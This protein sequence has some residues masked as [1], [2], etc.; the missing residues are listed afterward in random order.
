M[1]IAEKTTMQTMAHIE[2][3]DNSL[4]IFNDAIYIYIGDALH[5][6]YLF[7]GDLNALVSELQENDLLKN[8]VDGEL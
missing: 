2:Q 5:P 7:K 6:Q 1:A 4:N 3:G 8:K